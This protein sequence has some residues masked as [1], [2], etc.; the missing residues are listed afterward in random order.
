VNPGA[1]DSKPVALWAVPRSVST[2]FERVFVERGDFR[3][4]HEPFAV[5]YY[6]SPE[7]RSDR[8][9]EEGIKEENRFENVLS[10]ILRPSDK[11]AFLKDMAYYVADFMDAEFA[12]RFTNTFLVREPRY[13]LSS[14]HK[15]WTDFTFEETGYE[16]LHRLHGYAEEAGQEPVV[17]DASDLQEKP[18]ETVAAYCARIGVDHKPEAL[19]WQPREV[20][21]WKMWDGWHDDAENSTGLGAVEQEEVELPRELEDLYERCLPFYQ[22]LYEKRLR[23]EVSGDLKT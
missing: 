20:P 1:N 7:R 15:K 22:D 11:P 4:F 14:L 13:V 5:T 21:E 16:H 3:V 19:S 23:P 12:G 17:V 9:A 8:Y 2:A 18:E 6:H 10:E